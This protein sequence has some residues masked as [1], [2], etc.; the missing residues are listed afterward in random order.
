MPQQQTA[1]ASNQRVTHCCRSGTVS[2]I[3]G[4]NTPQLTRSQGHQSHGCLYRTHHQ[5]HSP[6]RPP[7]LKQNVSPKHRY[8]PST[9]WTP[10]KITYNT[11][12]TNHPN[13]W[14]GPT[15]E[16]CQLN[17]LYV[18]IIKQQLLSL[19]FFTDQTNTYKHLTFHRCCHRSND[20]ILTS[21]MS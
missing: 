11:A 13:T 19:S 9:T 21:R 4:M 20:V 16:I 1:R 2:V 3:T 8:A 15:S 6:I 7:S 18:G 14:E 5:L 17:T 10:T 12:K